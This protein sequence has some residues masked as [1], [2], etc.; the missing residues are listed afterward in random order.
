[1]TSLQKGSHLGRRQHKPIKSDAILRLSV[2][3]KGFVCALRKELS[4]RTDGRITT[5]IP[6]THCLSELEILLREVVYYYLPVSRES[7]LPKRVLTHSAVSYDK[8][9]YY[10]QLSPDSFLSGRLG[11]LVERRRVPNWSRHGLPS[12]RFFFV[13]VVTIQ[14]KY[15]SFINYA[16][17]GNHRQHPKL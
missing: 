10:Q 7:P 2:V 9:E 6:I 16:V 17:S 15:S 1:M 4:K 5:T 12:F 3:A 8:H 13:I 14:N 11:I